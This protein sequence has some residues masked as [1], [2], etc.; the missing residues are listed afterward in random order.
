MIFYHC[1]AHSRCDG[2]NSSAAPF[3]VPLLMR[4]HKTRHTQTFFF[5]IFVINCPTFALTFE[6]IAIHRIVIDLAHSDCVHDDS[7]CACNSQ[8]ICHYSQS[9]IISQSVI[10]KLLVQIKLDSHNHSHNHYSFNPMTWDIDLH[11]GERKCIAHYC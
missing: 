6:I 2:F 1:P 3:A 8:S 7:S 10:K 9:V 11:G 4:R 5:G